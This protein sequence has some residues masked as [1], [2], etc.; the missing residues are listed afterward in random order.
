[1]G[2]RVARIGAIVLAGALLVGAIAVW[3]LPGNAEAARQ[4]GQVST[5]ASASIQVADN[6]SG[7]VDASG[8][9]LS[10]SEQQALLAALE[11]EYKAWSFYEQVIAEFG[12]VRPF[13]SIQRAEEN[14]I[15]SLVSLFEAYGLEV[16]VN[17][18]V[19]QGYGDSTSL[20]SGP[21]SVAE[22]C[23]LGVQA[24]VDNAALYDE[25][26]AM[27]DNVDIVQVFAALQAASQTRH[28]PALER[29]AP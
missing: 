19:V 22:A 17:E 7:S 12:A 5:W 4:R 21:E 2:K 29:C 16:P 18:W 14:H 24:E 11:D 1:M 8:T 6:A 10:D 9:E 15:A 23:E 25:L 13:T 20:G 3:L 28:L 27:V 26:L